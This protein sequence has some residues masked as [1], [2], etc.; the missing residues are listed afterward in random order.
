MEDGST[1]S[2]PVV[3]SPPQSTTPDLKSP[4]ARPLY[5]S[6]VGDQRARAS[7]AATA[8]PPTAATAATARQPPVQQQKAWTS[9]RNPITGRPQIPQNKQSVTSSL[10]EGQRVRIVLT[11]GAE[12]EGTY[13]NGPEPTSCRLSMVQQK[14]LPSSTD[15]TNGPPRRDQP[16]MTIQRKE[17]AD[18]RAVSNNTKNDGRAPNGNRASF[19]TDAAISNSRLGPERTLKAWVPDASYETEGSLEKPSGGGQWDQFAE[20]ERLFGLKT[21]YDE[22]IYTTSIDKSH[23]Q[24]KER[25]AAAE[26][27]ARE[28]ERSAPTTSH[29]A[30]ERVMDF[31]G[32]E[33]Q[34]DEEDKYSGVRR[35]DFPPLA[36]RENKYTPPARRAPTGHSTVKGVPV[37]PAI[38][39]AQL[40][41]TPT[42][43]QTTPKPVESKSPSIA[44][45]PATPFSDKAAEPKPSVAAG[46]AEGKAIETKAD[47]TSDAKTT[48]AKDATAVRPTTT[49][50]RAA[51]QAKVGTV[52][53]ATSTVERD[54][55][56]SFKTFASSQRFMAE[57]ARTSKAKV[58]KEVK[59]TELKKFAENFKLFT[60]V[61]KDLISII[62]K[63]PAK[64]KKIQEKAK[65]NIDELAKQKEAAT[66]EKDVAAAKETQTKASAEQSGTSTPATGTADAQRGPRPAAP[67]HSG[68]AT[69]VSGRH[70]GA[71][72]SYNPQSHYQYSR[73]G[74]AP[75]HMAPQNQQPTGNLAQRLR[76]VE[77]QKLQHPHAGQ[78]P[79][80]DMRLPPTGP[81]NSVD[82]NFGRRMGAVP[83][84]SYMGPKLNPNSHEFRP[85]AFAQ[86]FN[87]AVPS[88]GS[89]PR[90]SVN[91]IAETP[92]PPAPAPVKG[93]LIRRKTK[94]V[95]VKKCFILS[96]IETIQPPQGRHWDDNDGLKPSFDTLPTWRQLQE[97]T[98]APDSTMHL[99][100]KEY[101]ERL[102]LSSAAVAT[103]NPTHVMPQVAH[104]HQL[105]FHLQHG[106]Q[107]LAPRQS[108]HMPPMQMH[109]GQ[110][111]HAPH[112]SFSN[113][114]DHRM[115]HSN[116]AQSFASPRMGP[117]PMAYPPSVNAPTP[118]PYGQPV[119]QG[120][121]NTA[122]QMG[123]FRSFSH[124]PQYMPQQ[125][126][127][128]G[129]PMMVQQGFMPNGM[130]A[131]GPMYA[132][133]QP[134]FM[135]AGAVPQQQVPGSNGFPSPGR[136]AAPMMV[137]QGSHQG[138]HQGQQPVYGMSPGMPYQQPAYTP[139]QPQGKFS[140]Q[141]PQ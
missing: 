31:V 130:M 16:T 91:H 122:P 85:N 138:S 131:A 21:D 46:A 74:R 56:V 38:I 83:P 139:Q 126:H 10:R 88:Q 123:Q 61:P 78:H 93:Q 5:S 52:P 12:F 34:R 103:P 120:Y 33:D 119:M 69:G 72:S 60:P 94:A 4:T 22:N 87:P 73:N 111:G 49:T 132:G 19:R 20:N 48:D 133:A 66:K 68:S 110:H 137:H 127:H 112:V 27:K 15:I 59:L 47:A 116:S 99:T 109:A 7:E 36:N 50:S 71:R 9:N 58:D 134:H 45:K 30:E 23:P 18:A 89:S 79:P 129:A 43:K 128:M 17:I 125:P 14:K 121:M 92:I 39:S 82:P 11:S 98:E 53:S 96:Y 1:A 135:P 105:P 40:K 102:P 26:R 76:N 140:G 106:A 44:E 136:P 70:P 6:K 107:N 54:V 42:S 86:P 95:N 2:K 37:D 41:S 104:Q 90:S 81:A 118:V 29:V 113:P 108:P 67:Q 80:P 77:Q 25:L 117:V 100:Y 65:H 32:G 114:D 8:S 62:A 84:P 75:S 101:F 28:I 55:L 64:Q 57:K 3:A 141:R 115:M 97:E 124:N 35:Q 13:S 24:Y 63:D 51:T